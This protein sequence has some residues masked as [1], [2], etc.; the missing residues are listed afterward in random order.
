METDKA[1]MDMETPAEGYLAKILVEPGIKDLPLGKVR[2][3]DCV[4]ALCTQF[5]SL[6]LALSLSLSLSLQP[7]CVIVEEEGD[8]PAFADFVADETASPTST[9]VSKIIL[10]IIIDSLFLTLKCKNAHTHVCTC[11]H[12][13]KNTHT[14]TG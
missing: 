6:A 8:V 9:T 1:T 4:Y 7:L 10:H 13:C 11:T 5:L 14:H 12:T 2:E 3:K